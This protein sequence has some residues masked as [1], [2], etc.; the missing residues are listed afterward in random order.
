[1]ISIKAER[2]PWQEKRWPAFLGRF[3]G[4][5]NWSLGFKAGGKCIVFNL[6]VGSIRVRWGS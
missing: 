1:M 2:W 4:G 6:L 3:G 5:W